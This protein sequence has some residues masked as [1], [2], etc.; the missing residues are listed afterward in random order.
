MT[1][2][3]VKMDAIKSHLV[4]NV[5]NFFENPIVFLEVLLLSYLK[6]RFYLSSRLVKI[7]L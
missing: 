4:V 1:P 6:V 7:S 2:I 5:L 3:K